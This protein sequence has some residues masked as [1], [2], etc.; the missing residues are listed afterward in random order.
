MKMI[1]L[2]LTDNNPI[3]INTD[4]ILKVEKA[5]QSEDSKPNE[6]SAIV[7]SVE[8]NRTYIEVIETISEISKLCNS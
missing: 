3:L 7:L 8:T 5:F 2:T 6:H 4:Y 1:K